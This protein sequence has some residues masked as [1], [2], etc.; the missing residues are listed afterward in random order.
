V[1]FAQSAFTMA[2]EVLQVRLNDWR[3]RYK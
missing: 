2:A 1:R 3:G